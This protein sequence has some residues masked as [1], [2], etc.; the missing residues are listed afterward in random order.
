[1]GLKRAIT[2]NNLIYYKS[3]YSMLCIIVVINIHDYNINQIIYLTTV[4]YIP[5]MQDTNILY[6]AI[7]CISM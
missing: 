2:D 3:Q 6:N 5:A 4:K 7:L 1:M